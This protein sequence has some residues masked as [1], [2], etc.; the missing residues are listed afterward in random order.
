MG[1]TKN[2]DNSYDYRKSLKKPTDP[3]L[4]K[5]KFIDL[6]LN[7]PVASLV[8]RAV[9]KTSITPNDLTYISFFLG[10]LGAFFFTRG[11]Y[12]Y[13]ILGGI[14]AQLCSIV[15]GA[16]GMLARAK[17]MCSDYGSHLDLFL[18]R[19]IDF[20]LFA[21]ISLGAGDY[22]KDN[23]LLFLGVLGSGLYLLQTNLFYI[24]KDYLQV[25]DKGETGE[26]R[27]VLIWAILIFAVAN[28]LDIFIY[29]GV[30]ETL[31]VN[32]VRVFYFV[33]LGKK[34]NSSLIEGFEHTQQ[35]QPGQQQ[36]NES[37]D[38]HQG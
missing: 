18:D 25:K 28:R 4:N 32:I 30:A 2:Q 34:K 22:F 10:L 31:I 3:F 33:S 20:C 9:Y 15:D 17:N 19:I 26:T 8:V 35:T 27:A 5:I 1:T 12:L 21:S 24:T 7:R 13:F 38:Q 37:S 29:L 6:Y 16:D 36:R 11:E 23:H 14:S